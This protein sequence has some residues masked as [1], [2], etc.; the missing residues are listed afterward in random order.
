M[1]FI[2][3]LASIPILTMLE[4][5]NLA[6]IIG[7]STVLLTAFAIRRWLYFANKLKGKPSKISLNI[8]DR[9]WL[10][11][12]IDFY[13]KLS[14]SDKKIFEDRIALFV[15]DIIITEIGKEVPSR[16]TCLY[17]ASSA[18]IT[19]WGLPYWNYGRLSEVL[20]YPNNFTYENEIDPQGQ[21]LGKVHQ[22]GLM[23]T[24]MI[25]SL[26]ALIA[27][28]LNSNDKNNVGIHEFAHLIDKADGLI[29]GVPV[30]LEADTRNRW[31]ELFSKEFAE[32]QKKSNDINQY[33]AASLPEFFAVIIEYYKESPDKLERNHKELFNLLNDY[34]TDNNSAKI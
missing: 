14:K 12:N 13:K 31:I 32:I 1:L 30:N 29:D 33:G 7:I 10:I 16:D 19:F 17:V 27:G 24:T 9:Y 2:I 22:G 21:I 34:F 8:N 6:K 4:Q 5:K 15:T 26:P 28:F 18:V 11:E 25:L 20:V 3:L 23:D